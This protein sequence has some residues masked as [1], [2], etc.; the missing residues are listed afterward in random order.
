MA[1]DEGKTE[2]ARRYLDE[3][4]KATPQPS[5]RV[6]S[7]WLLAEAQLAMDTSKPAVALRH[8]EK[9]AEIARREGSMDHKVEA[10]LGR[11]RALEKLGKPA[12][13]DA[14]YTQ[15]D[16]LLADKSLLIP[17]GSGRL[18]FLAR[19]NEVAKHRMSFLLRQADRNAGTRT[20]HLRAAVDV[21]RRNR[22]RVLSA[23]QW[24]ERIKHL[25]QDKRT[26]WE[27]SIA[28][29][30]DKRKSLDKGFANALDSS[31]ADELDMAGKK[32]EKEKQVLEGHLNDVLGIIA[33][34]PPNSAEPLAAQ[35]TLSPLTEGELLLVYHPTVDGWVGFAVT[36]HHIATAPI[37]NAHATMA[38]THLAQTLLEPFRK[39]IDGR[40]RIRFAA[41]GALDQIRFHALP[42]D[43]L[44][45]N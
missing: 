29:Y 44:T 1:L 4:R 17:M 40:V 37:K 38:P 32:Y 43:G 22:A 35:T 9:V 7:D 5:A 20:E 30:R 45:P 15:T 24:L 25:D 23:M 39:S 31:T 12:D 3:A 33:S 8:F 41:Y 26:V 10:A 13:A 14:A 42:L 27:K 2:D 34:P 28:D 16:A 36:K 11:A 18:S 6:E 19:Y 21:A